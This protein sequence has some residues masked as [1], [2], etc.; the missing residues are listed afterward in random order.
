MVS[1]VVGYMCKFS[2]HICTYMI[3]V[4]CSTCSEIIPLVSL[5]VCNACSRRQR[6]LL[7]VCECND[8]ISINSRCDAWNARN[9]Y[10]LMQ[11]CRRVGSDHLIFVAVESFR[12]DARMNL[13]LA[14]RFCNDSDDNLQEE[15]V[16][17]VNLYIRNYYVHRVMSFNAI[18]SVFRR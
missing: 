17:L 9:Y 15:K 11:K 7:Q 5:R 2:I 4:Q 12:R 6:G 3:Y 13:P 10:V 1:R 16:F 18:L 14:T 8:G